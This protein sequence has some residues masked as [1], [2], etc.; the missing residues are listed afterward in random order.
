MTDV[1]EDILARLVL[2]AG[3]IP[4]IRSTERNNI[5]I[6][7]EDMPA[8][9]VFDGDEETNAGT[10]TS[11]RPANLPYSVRMTPAIEISAMSNAV[12]SD[13]SVLRRDLIKLVLYDSQLNAIV[14]SNGAIRYL[15]CQT[16]LQWMRTLNGV[17]RVQFLFNYKLKPDEL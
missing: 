13:L 2:V 12:G 17:L 15:G 3:T 14:K 6:N 16:D 5:A 9:I 10:D 11:T 4:N 8:A 7:E 1:R